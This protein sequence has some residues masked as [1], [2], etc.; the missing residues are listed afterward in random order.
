MSSA[1]PSAPPTP[2]PMAASFVDDDC[3][4][5]GDT[6]DDDEVLSMGLGF[7]ASVVAV[8]VT[9]AVA[10][11]VTVASCVVLGDVEPEVRLKITSPAGM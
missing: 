10:V 1:S 9:V 11:M 4:D 5:E 3:G 7:G 8:V 2:A 6:D